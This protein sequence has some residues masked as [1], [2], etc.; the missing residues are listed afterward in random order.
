MVV[1]PASPGRLALAMNVSAAR[2]RAGRPAIVMMLAA[3]VMGISEAPSPAQ[4]PPAAPL[5]AKLTLRYRR[6]RSGAPLPVVWTFDWAEKTPATGALEYQVYDED[7][8]LA[9]FR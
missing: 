3:L 4:G 7:L 2:G 1:F 5:P 9:R 8:C 6:A